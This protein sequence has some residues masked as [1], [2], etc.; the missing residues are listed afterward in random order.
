MADTGS[1]SSTTADPNPANNCMTKSM[2]VV[3]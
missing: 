1:V 3:G 2:F